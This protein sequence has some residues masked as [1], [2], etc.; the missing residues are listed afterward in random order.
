MLNRFKIGHFT[1]SNHATGCTVIL[2][3]EDNVTSACALGAATGTREYALLLPDKKI[4]SVQAI[5][6]TGG[7][8]FGLNAAGGVVKYLEEQ[9][10]GYPTP[11]AHVPIVP[12]AVI[13]DLN[14]GSAAARPGPLEGYEACRQACY[15]NEAR[16]S[17]GVGTG[18]TVGKWAGLD[19]AMMGGWGLTETAYNGIRVAC[20]IAVNAVGDIYDTGNRLLCGARD[21]NTF[22]CKTPTDR[23]KYFDVRFGN[24]VIG[25]IMTNARI[26][27][28]EAHYLARRAHFGIARRIR[29]SHTRFDGDVLF[30]S[31]S[32]DAETEINIDVLMMM[33]T[34]TV[35]QAILSAVRHARSINGIPA[36][37]DWDR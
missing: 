9:G 22:L 37:T 10:L 26:T 35:E 13:Y 24:T 20:G 25:V 33:M 11:Y 30:V 23:F 14:V 36:L 6:L 31:S 8:A 34:D 28:Q 29:P 32:D 19:K 2:P 21:G 4:R 5:L 12:A 27:K 15:A 1:D 7:S 17:V 3:P 16:G 18:A